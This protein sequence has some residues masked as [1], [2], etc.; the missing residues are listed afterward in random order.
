MAKLN[1][2]NVLAAIEPEVETL[3]GYIAER[4]AAGVPYD[5]ETLALAMRSYSLLSGTHAALTELV[6]SSPCRH[7]FD[8]LIDDS[9]T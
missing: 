7:S 4:L 6:N 2:N 3:R 5:D 1:L 8:P 9:A